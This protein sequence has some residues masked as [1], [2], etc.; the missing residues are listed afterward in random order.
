[1]RGGDLHPDEQALIYRANYDFT[2][3]KVIKPTW[4]YRHDLRSGTRIPIA[5][6]AKPAWAVPSLNRAGTHLTYPRKDRHPSGR[7]WH[8]VEVDGKEDKG[9]LNF[10]DEVKIFARWFP[11]SQH[12]HVISNPPAASSRSITAWGYTT[13][14][15]APHWLVDD[16]HRS[17]ES[18][19]VSPNGL[20]VVNEIQQATHSP[21]ERQPFID[22]KTDLETRFPGMPGNLL[23]LGQAANGDWIAI[24]YTSTNPADLVRSAPQAMQQDRLTPAQ[25]TPL[26]GVWQRT[27]LETGRLHAAE[28][29]HWLSPDGL[30]F[31]GW[32][33]RLQSN[34]ERLI[35][36][37]HGGPSSHSEDKINP[38]IQYFLARGFNVLDVN[39][40]GSTGFG[41]KFRQSIG[42]KAG[43]AS[44][45]P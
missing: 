39:Y 42:S 6:P 37:I 33:Y 30:Q 14:P 28:T 24:Y 35:I 2:E 17:I 22:P 38:E 44:S 36:F 45:R 27:S 8:L 34:P 5:Y 29:F 41:L 23:P 4:V 25:L 19:L 18:A 9:I 40:R 20:V 3:D 16:P 13:S 31:Q 43:A 1:M 11:D 10:G 12:I 32:L 7:Q 15:A 26:T 21:S